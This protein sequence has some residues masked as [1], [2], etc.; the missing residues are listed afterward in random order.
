MKLREL[1][2]TAPVVTNNTALVQ[3]FELSKSLSGPVLCKQI[4]NRRWLQSAMKLMFTYVRFL[5]AFEVLIVY[6]GQPSE[7]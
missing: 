3:K 1:V 5:M 6:N 4:V 2:K 7:R